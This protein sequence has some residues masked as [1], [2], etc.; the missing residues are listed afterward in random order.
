MFACDVGMGSSAMGA[1][2]F[3][4]RIKDFNLDI[5][6]VNSSVAN[7]PDDADIIITHKG[8]LDSIKKRLI[9]IK[10]FL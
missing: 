5:E 10:L 6:V 9:R 4:N 7:I 2:N 8:L 1:T 3:R